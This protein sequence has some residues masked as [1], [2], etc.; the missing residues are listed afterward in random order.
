MASQILGTAARIAFFAALL[1]AAL[2]AQETPP[3]PAQSLRLTQAQKQALQALQA[4]SVKKAAAA[5]LR[6]A[7]AT[8]GF[9]ANLLSDAPDSE[10]DRKVDREMADTFAEVAQLRLARIRNA[11]KVLT[12]EQRLALAAELRKPDSPY[13]F[14][15]LV[16]KVLGDPGN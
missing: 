10:I 13:L 9:N 1:P 8:R 5:V 7:Q 12:R 6:M 3:K 4:D 15:D 11:A 14:D 2:P 16:R